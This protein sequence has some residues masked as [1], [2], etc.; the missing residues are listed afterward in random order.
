MYYKIYLV[1]ANLKVRIYSLI[2]ITPH[3]P[4]IPLPETPDETVAK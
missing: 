3:T 4:T 2:I 1:T